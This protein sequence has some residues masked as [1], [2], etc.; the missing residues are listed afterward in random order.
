AIAA[1]QSILDSAFQP[2]SSTTTT[3]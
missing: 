2:Q 3:G 1:C